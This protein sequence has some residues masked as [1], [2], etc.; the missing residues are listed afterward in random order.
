MHFIRY[1]CFHVLQNK[2]ANMAIQSTHFHGHTIDSIW[3]MS[4]GMSTCHAQYLKWTFTAVYSLQISGVLFYVILYKIYFPNI[5]F[6]NIFYLNY[7]RKK[8]EEWYKV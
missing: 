5:I 8:C 1:A 2:S 6:M 3:S 4:N 7:L